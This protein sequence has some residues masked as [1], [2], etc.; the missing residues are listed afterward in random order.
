MDARQAQ[1]GR[2]GGGEHHRVFQPRQ[3][4][5][6]PG[7]VDKVSGTPVGQADQLCAVHAGRVAV[8]VC[9]VEEYVAPVH[10]QRMTCYPCGEQAVRTAHHGAV[11]G[12]RAAEKCVHR[13]QLN[14]VGVALEVGFARY[15][16]YDPWLSLP[17]HDHADVR[18]GPACVGEGHG[19]TCRSRP[20]A[21]NEVSLA[22]RDAGAYFAG[23][24][25]F[26]LATCDERRAAKRQAEDRFRE[27]FREVHSGIRSLSRQIYAKSPDSP[28]Q[29]QKFLSLL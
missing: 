25:L 3:V 26:L 5:A 24:G 19:V 20:L 17:Q 28:K 22:P 1:A 12:P 23:N 6:P 15:G 27:S 4:Y 7:R 11:G 16:V 9:M 13:F 29:G 21:E 10:V 18:V 8:V 14:P 2:Q